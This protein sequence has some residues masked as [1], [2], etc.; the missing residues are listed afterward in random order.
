[1]YIPKDILEKIR[2][3]YIVIF[4]EVVG[5]IEG[6]I[7]PTGKGLAFQKNGVDGA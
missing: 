1:V 2:N 5:S 3:L 6:C 4:G 7:W